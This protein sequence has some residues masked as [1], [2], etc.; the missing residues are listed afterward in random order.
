VKRDYQPGIL[1]GCFFLPF[2]VLAWTLAAIALGIMLI[3]DPFLHEKN[4]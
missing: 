3:I 2:F 4:D 1:K